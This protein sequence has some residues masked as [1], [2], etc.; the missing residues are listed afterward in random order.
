MIF[1]KTSHGLPPRMAP[2]FISLGLF[3]PMFYGLLINSRLTDA[4]MQAIHLF[5][6]VWS[7]GDCLS[8]NVDLINVN[9]STSLFLTQTKLHAS[10]MADFQAHSICVYSIS[11]THVCDLFMDDTLSL[12]PKIVNDIHKRGGTVLGTSRGGHDTTKIVNSIEDR[13]INQVC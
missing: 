7:F 10:I 13:G 3:S 11:T 8:C 6:P 4:F 9:D 1:G 5:L 2:S 12:N